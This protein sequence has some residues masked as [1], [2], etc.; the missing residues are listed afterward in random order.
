MEVSM[1]PEIMS[2]ARRA[3][4]EAVS[5]WLAVFGEAVMVLLGSRR[6]ERLERARIDRMTTVV[7]P[8]WRT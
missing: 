1:D 8:W 5:R 3:R 7:W 4:G 2:A 6:L